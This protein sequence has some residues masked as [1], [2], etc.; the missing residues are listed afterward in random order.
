VRRAHNLAGGYWFLPAIQAYSAGV[1][2]DDGHHLVHLRLCD[3]VPLGAGMD[4]ARRLVGE[5]F[6]RPLAA[7]C[8]V[9]L[10]SPR[11]LGFREFAEFNTSYVSILERLKLLVRGVNP[12][13]R[14]NVVPV[15]DPPPE[16]S[17]TG[18]SFT[19]PWASG[20]PVGTFITSGAAETAGLSPA[21]IVRR[22]EHDAGALREKA[23]YTLGRI[24]RRVLDLGGRPD[25]ITG[26]N[27][28]TAH[29]VDAEIRAAVFRES[30]GPA[31]VQW[32]AA[33]PPIRELEF[34]VDVRSVELEM[35]AAGRTADFGRPA[36][37]ASR[38]GSLNGET[39]AD[40][41]TGQPLREVR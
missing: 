25:A 12:V 19:V 26:V 29:P 4:V 27:V 31:C 24:R 8:A 33:T 32:H 20:D 14:T 22:G 1:M 9:E 23:A 17:L 38:G 16:P 6:G 2:A 7:L 28:Y 21:L 13:A 10:R 35:V 41:D 40:R 37:A 39:G 15:Y 11:P 34:E 5:V 30:G 36:R 3:P 18:F